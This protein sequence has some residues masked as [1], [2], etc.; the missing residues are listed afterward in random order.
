MAT[1]SRRPGRVAQLTGRSSE[2]GVL[3]R[4]IEAH[5]PRPRRRGPARRAAV[6]AARS[7]FLAG[8]RLAAQRIPIPDTLAI[9]AILRSM[10]GR[11][12][13]INSHAN[14]AFR[15]IALRKDDRAA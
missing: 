13:A 5:L 14:S 3:D 15:S 8:N 6:K 2:T 12:G 10:R 7:G 9:T 1:H 4:L 11:L